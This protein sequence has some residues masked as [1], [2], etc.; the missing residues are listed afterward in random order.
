MSAECYREYSLEKIDS[1]AD[2]S[3]YFFPFSQDAP[4]QSADMGQV[5][6]VPFFPILAMLNT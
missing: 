3:S 5:G 2:E 1:A 4:L 6:V